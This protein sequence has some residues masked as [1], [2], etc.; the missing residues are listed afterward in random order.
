MS[1]DDV[2]VCEVDCL[3]VD[4]DA[5]ESAFGCGNGGLASAVVEDGGVDLFDVADA[6][7]VGHGVVGAAGVDVE[8]YAVGCWMVVAFGASVG[9]GRQLVGWEAGISE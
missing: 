4:G 1:G 7:G 9:L 8:Q 6:V 5:R 3:S 2:D